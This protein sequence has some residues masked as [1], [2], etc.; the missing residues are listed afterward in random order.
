M[1]I[2]HIWQKLPVH[3]SRDMLRNLLHNWYFPLSALAFFWPQVQWNIEPNIWHL[4]LLIA[5]LFMAGVATQVVD[6]WQVT[7]RHGWFVQ[8]WTL[9]STFGI[10]WRGQRFAY[11]ALTTNSTFQ[12]LVQGQSADMS[13]VVSI[14]LALC[15]FLFVYICLSWFW[16]K[17]SS[18]LRDCSIFSSLRHWEWALYGMLTLGLIVCMAHAFDITNAFYT[19]DTGGYDVIYTSDSG[20][21]VYNMGYLFL[22]FPENDLRQPLFAVFSAPFLGAPYFIG[23]ALSLS[24]SSQAILLNAV[25]VFLL[26]LANLLLTRLLSLSSVERACLM[27]VT[28]ITYSQLLSLLMMEQYIL[29]YFWLMLTLALLASGKRN[30]SFAL[31]GAGSTLLTSLFWA[32]LCSTHTSLHTLRSWCLDM[33]KCGLG[34]LMLLL[35]FGRFDVLYT[36]FD[37]VVSLSKFSGKAVPLDERIY[38]YTA[39]VHDIFLTPAA[40]A[41]TNTTTPQAHISW[42]LEPVQNLNIF[43]IA[44]LAL[45]LLSAILNR[46]IQSSRMAICWIGFSI[47]LLIGL[48]W[49]TKENGLI[50]YTLYFGWAFTLLLFQL[51]QRLTRSLKATWLLVIFS[52]FIIALLAAINFPGMLDL[53]HF[54]TTYFPNISH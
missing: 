29:A 11:D 21:L 50:L 25:Q 38:Q 20:T 26:V 4:S 32:P 3:T 53:I 35:A 51:L 52:I 33:L 9:L 28:S 41:G 10:L 39:F 7:R 44:V 2:T 34:Y 5:T 43:G 1:T 36:L 31:Y 15:G 16:S 13:R 40:A 42:M 17:L 37:K 18:L 27:L 23:Q 47:L 30:T 48:G 24:L 54:G 45:V 49:G 14:A 8:C 12:A 46:K 22:T 19:R 6:Y